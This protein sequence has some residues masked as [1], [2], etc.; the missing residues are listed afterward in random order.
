[1]CIATHVDLLFFY[2]YSVIQ[3]SMNGPAEDFDVSNTFDNN[4]ILAKL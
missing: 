4:K 1:M 2:F 3:P